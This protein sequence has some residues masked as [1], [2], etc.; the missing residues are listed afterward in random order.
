MDAKD[1]ERKI[2]EAYFDLTSGPGEW[3]TLVQ[4]REQLGDINRH[5]VDAALV[6]LNRQ[7]GV[8]FVPESN[9]RMLTWL[10]RQCA[11]MIGDQAKH[12]MSIRP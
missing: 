11:V 8:N 7:P 9:Q 10:D 5:E 3:V 6:L 12:L 1:L 4:L 2:R